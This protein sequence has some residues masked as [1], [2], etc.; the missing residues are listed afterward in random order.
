[1]FEK[2]IKM[3]LGKSFKYVMTGSTKAIAWKESS[4]Y[5]GS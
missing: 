5:I 4:E 2:M 3:I 1:M